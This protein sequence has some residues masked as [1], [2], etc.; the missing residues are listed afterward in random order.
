M[1]HQ[2]L[3]PEGYTMSAFIVG[4][5]HIDALLS[6]A[7][8]RDTY[9]SVRYYIKDTHTSVEITKQNATEI[10][11]ILL[12]ENERSIYHRYPDVK[13]GKDENKPGTWGED[14]E[15]YK[16]KPWPLTSPLSAVSILKA[17]DCF[18]Y[19]ACETDDYEQSLAHT[20]INAIRK[21]AIHRVPGYD[22]AQGWEFRRPAAAAKRSA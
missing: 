10:G 7:M 17:C 19:Q 8:Q 20:I 4:H 21:R 1:L 6:F 16:F 13:P 2:G 5:D 12:T 9:G 14:A 3:S 11:R 15:T 18:D 22:D